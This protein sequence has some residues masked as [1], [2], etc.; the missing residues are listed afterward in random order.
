MQTLAGI[1]RLQQLRHLGTDPFSRQP[2]DARD[3]G[4]AG[5]QSVGIQT[6]VRVAIPGVKAEKSQNTQIVLGDPVVGVVDEP[7]VP[8]QQIV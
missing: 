3:R 5:G 2:G 7:H 6:A 1:G 4:S 8:R